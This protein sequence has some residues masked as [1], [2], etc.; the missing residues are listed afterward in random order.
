MHF[1]TIHHYNNNGAVN[2]LRPLP[3]IL[4]PQYWTANGLYPEYVPYS[5]VSWNV[6]TP[7]LKNVSAV[8]EPYDGILTVSGSGNMRDYPQ[9]SVPWNAYRSNIRTIEIAEG[10]TKIGNYA[11]SAT[12]IKSIV[13]PDGV[14]QIGL[15]AFSNTAIAQVDIPETVSS[16]DSAAFGMC[17]DLDT[18]FV[19]WTTV[20]GIKTSAAAFDGDTLA[21]ITLVVPDGRKAMYQAYEPWKYMNVLEI[22]ELNTPPPPADTATAVA[23]T[24]ALALP[25]YPNPTTGVVYIDNP[26]NAEVVVYSSVGALVM[27]TQGDKIDLSDF[28]AGVYVVRVGQRSGKIVKK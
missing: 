6:G 7:T 10:I 12:D 13:V 26:D 17:Y 1:D 21:A 25:L 23:A 20:S 2:P 14:T 3:P 16:I 8:Y 22:N 24:E 27:R 11:F 18:V 9:K 15:F 28:A 19:H 4:T 5:P